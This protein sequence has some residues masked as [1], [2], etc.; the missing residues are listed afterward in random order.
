[1][2]TNQQALP[3]DLL[4]PQSQCLRTVRSEET[5]SKLY[6]TELS[7]TFIEAEDGDSAKRPAPAFE[8][9]LPEH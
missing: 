6:S 5:R 8:P 7:G 2:T 4:I 1:M 9:L 3:S